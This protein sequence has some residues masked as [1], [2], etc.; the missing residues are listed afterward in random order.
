MALNTLINN[1]PLLGQPFTHP[2]FMEIS[3]NSAVPSIMGDTGEW[4]EEDVNY[5]ILKEDAEMAVE[6]TLKNVERFF[7][8]VFRHTSI[9][10]LR[11]GVHL[12]PMKGDRYTI[13]PAL[14]IRGAGSPLPSCENSGTASEIVVVPAQ[15]RLGKLDLPLILGIK[16]RIPLRLYGDIYCAEWYGNGAIVCILLAT[17]EYVVFNAEFENEGY[18]HP[19][20]QVTFVARAKLFHLPPLRRCQQL[21]D[22]FGHKLRPWQRPKLEMVRMD[23]E[24]AMQRELNRYIPYF[25]ALLYGQLTTLA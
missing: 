4:D 25:K 5:T 6:C 21:L 17:S 11:G 9:T 16:N 13:S 18:H 2:N 8:T 15:E 10:R 3:L 1:L 20:F 23:I 24:E 19:P 7:T 22:Q 14:S 12:A